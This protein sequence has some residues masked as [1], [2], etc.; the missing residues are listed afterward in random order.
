MT[1]ART[2]HRLAAAAIVLGGL[3]LVSAF[4]SAASLRIVPSPETI[5]GLRSPTTYLADWQTTTAQPALTPAP[6][7]ALLSLVAATPTPLPAGAAT[8]LLGAGTV[9]HEALEWQFTEEVGLATGL[10]IEL[11]FQIHDTIA[12][13]A[14]T[15]TITAY[16]ETSAAPVGAAHVYSLYFDSTAITGVVFVSEYELAQ[17]CAAVGACP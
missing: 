14:H 7:P 10:E 4:V 12:G 17:G 1:S 8:Y 9:G 5:A 6:L 2:R 3:L 16:L 13:V 15:A 11:G